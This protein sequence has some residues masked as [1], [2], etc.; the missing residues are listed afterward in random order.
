MRETVMP[1]KNGC[2]DH[3]AGYRVKFNGLVPHRIK[4]QHQWERG[5][6]NGNT[7]RV[8][9]FWDRTD[10]MLRR[11]WRCF[12]CGKFVWDEPDEIYALKHAYYM[13]FL[14]DFADLMQGSDM[15]IKYQSARSHELSVKISSKRR[16]EK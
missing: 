15:K 12:N 3:A 8:L 6:W 16:D 10:G 7:K 11:G 1:D 9:P 4:D 2:T 13:G 14:P 5:P